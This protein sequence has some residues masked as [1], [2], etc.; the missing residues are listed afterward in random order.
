VITRPF[1]VVMS[2]A[3][4]FDRNQFP[5]PDSQVTAGQI[6]DFDAITYSTPAYL[7]IITEGNR[8]PQQI[9]AGAA[10]VRVNLAGAAAGLAMHPNEQALQEYPAVAAPYQAIHA[11]LDAPAPDFTVQML[12]RVGYLPAN[13]TAAPPA[14]RRGLA[15]HVIA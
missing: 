10:Y 4:L 6:K 13:A 14:P 9:D 5:A 15:A 12:A 8:R 1:V 2:K 3:G 11:L 7:W